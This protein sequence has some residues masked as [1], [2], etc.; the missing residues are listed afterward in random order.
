MENDIETL[1]KLLQDDPSN[2]QARRE[3]S[4]LLVNNGFNEEAEG[5]LQYLCKY[6]PED[7]ELYYN[8]GIVYEKLKKYDKAKEVYEK[9]VEISPQEDF[10]Y[11]ISITGS[12]FLISGISFNLGISISFGLLFASV[13]CSGIPAFALFTF[14]IAGSG[15]FF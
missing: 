3:L 15:F 9:A 1:Q 4:I 10:Y 7:A 14:A 6:F 13:G 5:N 8:L 11:K 12:E 2:F